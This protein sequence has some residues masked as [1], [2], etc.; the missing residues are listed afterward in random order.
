MA[1]P[2]G[3]LLG[4]P[5]SPV[6]EAACQTAQR[7]DR[8]NIKVSKKVF[9]INLKILRSV[10]KIKFINYNVSQ[11]LPPRPILRRSAEDEKGRLRPFR[12]TVQQV[13]LL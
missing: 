10:L 5:V 12:G 1:L 8:L 2:E 6:P 4:G 13:Q 9:H 3:D 11:V 7:R